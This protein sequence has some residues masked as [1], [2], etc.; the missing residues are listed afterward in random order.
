MKYL[1]AISCVM[2]LVAS[3]G[4]GDIIHVPGDCSTIQA[5]IQEAVSGD[6]VLVA[7]GV[8]T[9]AGNRDLSFW[10]KAITVMSESG[11]VS[12]VIDC[13]GTEG[14]PHRG[15]IFSKG[16][17]RLSVVEGF[18]IRNGYCKGCVRVWGGGIMILNSSPTIKN[19]IISDNEAG[20]GGGI[21]CSVNSSPII[22]HCI[23]SGNSAEVHGAGIWC[24]RSNPT[25]TNCTIEGNTC[26]D[27]GSGIMCDKS[28]ATITYCTITKNTATNNGGGI[29]CRE[30]DSII[31]HCVITENSV[32]LIGGGVYCQF[33]DAIFDC[34]VISDNS[35]TSEPTTARS[36]GYG[37]GGMY[38]AHGTPSATN[39]IISGNV[40]PTLGGGVRFCSSPGILTNCT[41]T[42]NSADGGSGG[43]YCGGECQ[44][45]RNCIVW[46]NFPDA[47]WAPQQQPA[48]NFCNIEGGWHGDGNIDEDPRFNPKHLFSGFEYSL[49]PDS[50]CIDAGDPSI[51]DTI[52]DLHLRWPDGLSNGERSDMGAYGGPGNIDWL[53]YPCFS[54]TAGW[55]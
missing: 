12:T 4:F 49:R 22:A 40:S 20:N 6:T 35:V 24:D 10:G 5:G 27:R 31:K 43:I 50:P 39:C 45:F 25:I 7:E 15:F 34:C 38:W 11:A 48:V 32:G 54:D 28:I 51:Y 16:E 53:I 2:L 23:L 13:E 19:C 47:I 42:G 44:Q 46:G 14:D 37:G 1:I 18:T 36:R 52:F 30:S 41:I 29:M 33:S 26:Y 21:S 9:G 8:Y 55:D 3:S 17:T